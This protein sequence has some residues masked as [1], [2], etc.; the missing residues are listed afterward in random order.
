MPRN[1]HIEAVRKGQLVELY[2]GLSKN[3]CIRCIKDN[4]ICIMSSNISSKCARCLQ[5]RKNCSHR[6]RSD[7]EFDRHVQFVKKKQQELSSTRELIRESKT[8]I[9]SLKAK[10]LRIQKELTFLEEKSLEFLPAE[11]FSDQEAEASTSSKGNEAIPATGSSTEGMN[12]AC[13]FFV[14]SAHHSP[15]QYPQNRLGETSHRPRSH[16][17]GDYPN[18]HT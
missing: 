17:I 14:L 8:K 3:P 7:R 16:R 11:A 18:P 13:A 5:L 10:K 6:E 2:S 12:C 4:H 1:T 9:S 15:G